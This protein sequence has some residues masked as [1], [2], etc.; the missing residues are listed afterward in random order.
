MRQ[1]ARALRHVGKGR[2]LEVLLLQASPLLGAAFGGNSA[3]GIGLGRLAILLAGS[4]LLTAHVFAFNDWAGHRDDLNDPRRAPHV[5]ARHGIGSRSVAALAVGLLAFAMVALAALGFTAVL[6][7]AAIACLGIL[8]SDSNVAG[9][10]VPVVASVIHLL[11]GA[12]HF[13]LGYGVA[14]PIDH[15]G[16][17][18]ALFFGLVFAGGHLNQEVRD[19]EGDQRNGIRTSAVAFGARSVLLASLVVFSTAYAELALLAAFAVVPR[20][21]LWT[22]L[23]WPLHAAWSWSALRGGAG[24]EQARWLQR[25]YRLLFAVVGVAMMLALAWRA[26]Y[27][28]V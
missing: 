3:G 19:Y 10:G 12:L 9:K 16:L 27:F 6:L 24:F 18:I 8:Y 21:L 14:R 20:L 15:H 7:G 13:L 25:R 23:L 11:G 1:T 2:S 17:A 22:A 28:S 4:V 26:G 5:F